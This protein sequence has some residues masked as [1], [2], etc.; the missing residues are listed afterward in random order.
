VHRLRN[1]DDATFAR[2]AE[3]LQLD[4]QQI[5]WAHLQALAWAETMAAGP[6]SLHSSGPSPAGP[7]LPRPK[8]SAMHITVNNA[9]TY[10]DIEGAGLVP[11]GASMCQRPALVLL[12]G[13]EPGAVG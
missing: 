7:T 12:H 5:N 10:V 4:N 8:T 9:R 2:T 3:M 6:L 11:D 1:R 13:L